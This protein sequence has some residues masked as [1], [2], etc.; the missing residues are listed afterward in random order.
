[1]REQEYANRI[2]NHLSYYETRN[3]NSLVL[4]I[5]SENEVTKVARAANFEIADGCGCKAP[6]E[7]LSESCL[8]GPRRLELVGDASSELHKALADIDSLRV[9]EAEESADIVLVHS[10]GEKK[11][12][13]FTIAAR[14][15]SCDPDD[16]SRAPFFGCSDRI[17]IASDFSPKTKVVRRFSRG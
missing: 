10:S 8:T 3:Q 4:L 16:E 17:G 13:S 6:D 12:F 14:E 2:G 9:E 15:G 1:M 11:L 7:D 5:S